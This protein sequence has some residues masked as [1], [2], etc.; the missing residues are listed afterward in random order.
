[1]TDGEA[2]LEAARREQYDMVVLDILMPRLSGTEVCRRL[3]TDSI[4]PIVMLTRRTRSSI[5]C[6]GSRSAP[7]TT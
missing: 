2:A 6:S 7:T 3:R 5:A 4:V 1:M